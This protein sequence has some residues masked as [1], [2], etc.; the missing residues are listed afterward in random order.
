M[1]T[2]TYSIDDDR[3][4]NGAGDGLAVIRIL[5]ATSELLVALPVQAGDDAED[6]NSKH[7]HD[8]AMRRSQGQH[9]RSP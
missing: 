9:E 3:C 4:E 2:L 1:R 8:G 7:G 6:D 5:D